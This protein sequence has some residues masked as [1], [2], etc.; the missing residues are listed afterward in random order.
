MRGDHTTSDGVLGIHVSRRG[1]LAGSAAGALGLL[2]SGC[3]Q[4]APTVPDVPATTGAVIYD[5]A[6][7]AVESVT[8]DLMM[9]G[10]VLVHP[11]VW[12][13][14][15][16]DDGSY[17]FG[18]L[19]SHVADDVA[20]ADIALLNQETI[21]GGTQLGLS[22]YPLFNGPQEIGDAEAAVG[23]TH[24]ACAS[25][26]CLDMGFEG[27]EGELGFW[28]SKH[29][30]VVPLG[31]ATS[32]EA[33]DSI[34]VFERDGLRVALLNYTFGTNGI[35]VPADEPW[36]CD[37]LDEAE[38]AQ[39]VAA[40]RAAAD[41]VVFLPHWGTEYNLGTDQ[42]Q[43]DWAQSLCEQ[44]VDVII[45]THP[46]VI[47]PVEV[48]TGSDGHR[49][50]VFWSLGNFVSAQDQAAR[51]VGGMAKVR[52][53]KDDSGA[54]VTSYGFVPLVDHKVFGRVAMTTYRLADYT[55]ELASANGILA[56]DATFSLQYC[57]DLCSQVLGEGFD[58]ET[59]VL[60]ASMS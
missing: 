30:E 17:D 13:S 6:A 31:I 34:T 42:Y 2:M 7:P 43:L 23:F 45:G 19:F 32:Q 8:V 47:E 25:N 48:M 59:C 56:N 40:A 20:A 5:E 57:K 3:A 58:A 52:M 9:V 10:D 29:P 36:C 46:H 53:A 49:M 27:I 26:H 12:Q 50:L 15:L 14:G 51:M 21:L 44:G 16:R 54:H 1:L 28:R 33:H 22:G 41:L 60:E 55:D 39:D 4:V 37:V 24:V 38:V 35:E 11:G 18:H